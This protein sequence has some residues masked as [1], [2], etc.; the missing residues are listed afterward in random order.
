M[1]RPLTLAA[2][3][4][5]AGAALP[6][7]SI[8]YAPGEFRYGVVSQIKRRDTRGDQKQDYTITT[9]QAM[10]LLLTPR[11]ND[12][13]RFRMTLDAYTIGSDLPVKLPD[14]GRL[15]GTIVEG[16]MTAYG[17]MVHYSHRAP[18][19]A[20]GGADVLELAENMSQ[21]LITLAP[22]AANGSSRTDTTSSHNTNQGGD[23]TERTIT[24]TTVDGD[25]VFAGQP[26][27]R[28]RRDMSVT[29]DG[30]TMQGTQLL[31]VTGG[32]DGKGTFYLS[33]K[34][35][36]LGATTR[37]VTNTTITLPDGGAIVSTQEALSTIT[38]AAK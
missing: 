19:T 5:A 2:L 27:W 20:G 7:Q 12:S 28:I 30:T 13:L 31:Q 14:V 8:R 29:V 23:L 32:G 33:K 17:R 9:N 36:Y 26:A 15:Q 6:A 25:T 1:P 37:T 4:L 35:V 10:S 3:A 18:A 21:F 11:G 34:G 22:D 24:T 16:V 38:L